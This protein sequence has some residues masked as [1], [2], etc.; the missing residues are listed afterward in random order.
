MYQ[1]L[2]P[3]EFDDNLLYQMDMFGQVIT[4]DRGAAVMTCQISRSLTKVLSR[5]AGR[6]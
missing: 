4:V 6:H 1:S 3:L 5:L 2:R